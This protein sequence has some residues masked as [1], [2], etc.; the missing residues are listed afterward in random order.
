MSAGQAA[1]VSNFLPI[2]LYSQFTTFMLFDYIL[3]DLI[4]LY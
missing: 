2:N 3:P 4:V 1:P